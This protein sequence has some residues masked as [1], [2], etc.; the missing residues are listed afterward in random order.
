MQVIPIYAPLCTM[1]IPL[2]D[3]TVLAVL[4]YLNAFYQHSTHGNSDIPTFQYC[5]IPQYQHLNNG[6]ICKHSNGSAKN[7]SD[8]IFP[9]DTC[10]YARGTAIWRGTPDSFLAIGVEPC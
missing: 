1:N 6:P 9:I 5:N 2:R 7:R 4:V 3:L 10:G 8:F